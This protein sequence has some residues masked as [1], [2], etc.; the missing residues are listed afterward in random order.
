MIII[1]IILSILAIALGLLIGFW[2]SNQIASPF[3]V[4]YV[5]PNSRDIKKKIY[6]SS[7]TKEYFKLIPEICLSTCTKQ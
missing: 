4:K 7:D 2:A 1:N 3:K 5:G 6:Y